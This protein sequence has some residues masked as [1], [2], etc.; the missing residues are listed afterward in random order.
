PCLA[1][2]A[3]DER[4]N[5]A[6]VAQVRGDDRRAA[7]TLLDALFRLLHGFA[8][9]AR[10][11][12]VSA[13]SAEL[14]GDRAADTARGSGHDRGLLRKGKAHASDLLAGGPRQADVLSM[15][16]QS[17]KSAGIPPCLPASW[18]YRAAPR[19][20]DG[21]HERS[22]PTQPDEDGEG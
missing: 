9:A 17:E 19:L 21:K 6:H 13:G 1:H 20:E 2:R 22:I 10:E 14:L 5:L 4:G 18:S 7:R 8:R 3:L 16:C 11:V 12:D 15:R